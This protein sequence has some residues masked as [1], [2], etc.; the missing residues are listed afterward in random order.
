MTL[1]NLAMQAATFDLHNVRC[2]L[3]SKIAH[4]GSRIISLRNYLCGIPV[5]GS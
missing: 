5:A 3:R 4:E 1:A 2:A